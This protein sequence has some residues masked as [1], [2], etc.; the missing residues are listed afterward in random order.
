VIVLP[1]LPLQLDKEYPFEKE[2][3]GKKTPLHRTG[4]LMTTYDSIAVSW[5]HAILSLAGKKVEEVEVKQDEA[6]GEGELN[7]NLI[8]IG[9]WSNRITMAAIEKS[10]YFKF[11]EDGKGGY[12]SSQKIGKCYYDYENHRSYG[13]LLKLRNVFQNKAAILVAGLSPDATTAAAYYLWSNREDL[14]KK[15]STSSFGILVKIDTDLGYSSAEPIEE[16]SPRE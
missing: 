11:G 4:D 14:A 3:R 12:I 9:A 2:I 5:I 10:P 13:I 15:Y 16:W 8:C 1:K 6:F 7:V